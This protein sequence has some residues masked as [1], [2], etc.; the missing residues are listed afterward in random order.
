[1]FLTRSGTKLI[2]SAKKEGEKSESNVKSFKKQL[3]TVETYTPTRLKPVHKK[4]KLDETVK[5]LSL[6]NFDDD[7][8]LES[9][10]FELESDF[11]LSA[12]NSPTKKSP[13][14]MKPT[15]IKKSVKT[16]EITPKA[17]EAISLISSSDDEIYTRLE[18]DQ[19]YRVVF[20]RINYYL[21]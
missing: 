14:V 16:T 11:E 3:K 10:E 17:T 19:E 20:L 18:K 7:F 1:M 4:I 2:K 5:K 21:N 8:E 15:G 6:D 13:N 9:D 12:N